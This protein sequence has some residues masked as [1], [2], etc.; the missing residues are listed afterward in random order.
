MTDNVPGPREEAEAVPAP[1]EEVPATESVVLTEEER[2]RQDGIRRLERRKR[3]MMSPEERLAKITGRPVESVSSVSDLVSNGGIIPPVE[4]SP[5]AISSSMVVEDDPPLENLTRDPFTADTPTMEGEFLTNLLGGQPT[6][7]PADPVQF[8]LIVW[9][10]LAVAVRL[11]LET[12]FSWT[13][14]NNMVAPFIVMVTILVTTGYLDI[15]NLQANSLLTAALMLCGVDQRKVALLTRVL[16]CFRILVQSFS[17][18]LV[19]FLLCHAV[20]V[21]VVDQL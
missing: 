17:I 11:L 18:Y 6:T 8:S 21:H 7:S 14:G 9:L 1:P 4:A 13:V 15:A 20:L 5:A 16:H 12:E 3:K 2:L 10:F 19:S